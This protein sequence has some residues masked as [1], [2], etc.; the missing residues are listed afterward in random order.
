MSSTRGKIHEI[1]KGTPV[2]LTSLASHLQRNTPVVAHPGDLMGF[3]HPLTNVEY[4]Y[5]ILRELNI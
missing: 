2:G 1:I 5:R 3:A 4:L